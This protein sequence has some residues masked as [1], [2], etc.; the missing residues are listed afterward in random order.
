[1]KAITQ[2]SIYHCN[3]Q[4]P[5]TYLTALIWFYL[6]VKVFRD[7]ELLIKSPYIAQKLPRL[8]GLMLNPHLMQKFHPMLQSS[9]AGANLPFTLPF[10]LSKTEIN[11]CMSTI[12]SNGTRQIAIQKNIFEAFI[13]NMYDLLNRWNA[14]SEFNETP[15]FIFFQVAKISCM[16]YTSNRNQIQRKTMTSPY[17]IHQTCRLAF[18]ETPP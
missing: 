12:R 6:I 16:T 17:S 10:Q 11:N 15:Y 5:L 14:A 7:H 3:K 18:N 1:M 13:V 9:H 2:S 8:F 4:R